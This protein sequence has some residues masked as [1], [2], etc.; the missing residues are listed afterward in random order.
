MDR[1]KPV[2][3]TKKEIQLFSTYGCMV[4]NPVD[5]DEKDQDTKEEE[6][7]SGDGVHP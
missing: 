3:L 7:G 1:E 4:V 5:S 2:R 6:H